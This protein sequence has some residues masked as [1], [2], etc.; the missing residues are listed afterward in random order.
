MSVVLLISTTGFTVSK[1]Y[2]GDKYIDFAINKE[3]KTCCDLD[4]G[5]C[6]TESEH[7]QLEKDFL[8]KVIASDFHDLGVDLLFL[9]SFSII[10]FELDG[11][12][13]QEVEIRDLPPPK[14]QTTLSLLQTYLC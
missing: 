5:C 11:E 9:V 4:G 12:Q 2:C 13:K 1:H 3:A 6:H 7:L 14:I 10:D 8:A